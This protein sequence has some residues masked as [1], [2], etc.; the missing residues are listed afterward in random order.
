MT[1][2]FFTTF[3]FYI[4]ILYAINS[5]DDVL[6]SAV[7]ELPLAAIYLQATNSKSGATGLLVLF[8]IDE[9]VTIP[10]AFIACGRMLWTLARDDAT[11]FSPYVASISPRFRNQFVATV[12]C[13]CVNTLLGCIYIGSAQAFNSFVGVFTIFTT[14]SYLATILPHLLSRR[15][16]LIPGPF[17]MPA[18][19]AYIVG[20]IA[21]TYIILFN[22]TFMFPYALPTNA[23]TMNY[24]C[25]MSGGLTIIVGVWYLW[26]RSHGY[27]GPKVALQANDEILHGE[28]ALETARR[29]SASVGA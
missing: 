23:Q 10:G 8:I 20:G 26:K 17:W 14:M 16:Y 9:F 19:W 24:S 7:P 29:A 12:I 1:T 13:G 6:N 5:L 15:K 4:A 18:P 22:V 2:G 27:V 11:P 25:V 21:C 28:I 3:T